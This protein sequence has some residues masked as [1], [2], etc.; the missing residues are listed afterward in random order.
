MGGKG[1]GIEGR[2]DGMRGDVCG[3]EDGRVLK[4][5]SGRGRSVW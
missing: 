5:N 4:W 3:G 1:V 2:G